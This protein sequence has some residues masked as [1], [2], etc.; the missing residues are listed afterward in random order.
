MIAL[1]IDINMSSIAI[2]P[3]SAEVS[4]RANIKPIKKVI[5]ELAILSRKL[6]LTPFTAFFFK[7]SL[8][9]ILFIYIQRTFVRQTT[10]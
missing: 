6:Q 9:D 10:S 4:I 2:I 7:E 5:T 8:I 1:Q 3:Y